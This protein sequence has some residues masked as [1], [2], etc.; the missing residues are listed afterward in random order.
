MVILGNKCDLEENREVNT[1]DGQKY[2]EKNNS[3]FFEVSAKTNT[4]VK[5][6]FEKVIKDTYE[7]KKGLSDTGS[8]QKLS[9]K[10]NKKKN[11]CCK[12]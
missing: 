3:P 2:A 12:K 6:A 5:E 11:N 10:G 9:K 4:N 8:G 7:M 1:A